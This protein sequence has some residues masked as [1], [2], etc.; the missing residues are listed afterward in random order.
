[1]DN[2]FHRVNRLFTTLRAREI[3]T[4]DQASQKAGDVL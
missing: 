1:M 4:K 3:D 2:R